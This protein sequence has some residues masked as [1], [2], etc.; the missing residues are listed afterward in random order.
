MKIHEYD[1]NAQIMTELGKRLRDVRISEAMLQEDVA[2][3][4][5]SSVSTVNRIEAGKGVN[6]EHILNYMRAVGLISNLDILVSERS[7]NLEDM[8]KL[9]KKRQRASRRKEIK[10]DEFI[11][12]EDR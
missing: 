6:I 1:S 10:K 11:W 4:S 12:G 3:L 2:R 8:L 9:N 7:V 5:G